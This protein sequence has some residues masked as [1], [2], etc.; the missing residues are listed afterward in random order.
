M[1]RASKDKRD[2]YYRR[3]K[4]T[5]YRAR[6][7]FKL[8]QIDRSF[9]LLRDCKR[10][11]DLCAAPGGW[12]EVIVERMR[13]EE[14]K[15]INAMKEQNESMDQTVPCKQQPQSQ[16]GSDT[17]PASVISPTSIA[18]SASSSIVPPSSCRIVAVD[19]QAM[20]PL[21]GVVFIKG[22]LTRA[23]TAR[24]IQKALSGDNVLEN[25][26]EQ[27]A[28]STL[29]ASSSPSPSTSS[30]VTPSSLADLVVCDGAPDVIGLP[31]H[32]E[33]IQF[34]LL[35]SALNLSLHLLRPRGSF[36]AKIFRGQHSR[37]VLAL[38]QKYFDRVTMSKPKACRN[39]SIEAFV[40]CQGFKGWSEE[41][42][43]RSMEEDPVRVEEVD[44]NAMKPVPFVSCWDEEE[45]DSDQSYPLTYT[46]SARAYRAGVRP[47]AAV[48]MN[49]TL[50]STSPS[51]SSTSPSPPSSSSLA[52]Q[53]LAPAVLPIDPPYKRSLQMKK[54][55]K[56]RNQ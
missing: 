10:V 55:N 23:S 54:Q 8:L 6:S 12:T 25:K 32:D 30:A 22:D 28:S 35:L 14:D 16:I 45:L 36:V 41:E 40:V 3:A 7:A 56:F 51:S 11:V 19:L 29:P 47:P 48:T 52:Y 17:M 13:E 24:A 26:E 50:P 34:E 20:A 43:G 53:S 37:C 9:D 38:M 1:G 39:S 31:D 5:G 49:P 2:I 4:E 18:S 46:F 15:R 21:P 33:R 27:A 42:R 44:I